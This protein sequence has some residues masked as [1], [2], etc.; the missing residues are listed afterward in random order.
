[1]ATHTCDPYHTCDCCGARIADNARTSWPR[2]AQLVRSTGKDTCSTFS[3]TVRYCESYNF[4]D[5]DLCARCMSA[6]LVD[7]ACHIW[8]HECDEVE[9]AKA[10]GSCEQS[11]NSIADMLHIGDPETKCGQI[12]TVAK[13]L[14]NLQARAAEL[15]HDEDNE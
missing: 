2:S 6:K 4:S 7:L 11:L 3:V 14:R 9:L 15:F 8:P 12:R 13:R 1:M 10:I 5:G